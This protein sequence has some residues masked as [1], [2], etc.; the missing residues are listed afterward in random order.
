MSKDIYDILRNRDIP[1][2]VRIQLKEF[3]E[4]YDGF[5]ISGQLDEFQHF[6]SL[7]EN[8]YDLIF[9][10]NPAGQIVYVSPRI[11]RFGY[12]PEEVVGQDMTLFVHPEDL[13][14]VQ[15]DF[16]LTMRTGKTFPTAFRM[17]NKDG[18]YTHVE[19]M[20]EAEWEN[21]QIVRF[22]GTLRDITER[23]LTEDALTEAEH[24]YRSMFEHI[25]DVYFK[26]DK[27]G[28]LTLISPSGVRLLGYPTAMDV[29]GINFPGT[30]FCRAD[31]WKEIVVHLDKHSKITNHEIELRDH[32]G[33]TIQVEANLQA[34]YDNNARFVGV[35]GILRDITDKKATKLARRETEE[36]YRALVEQSHDAIFIYQKDTTVFANRQALALTGFTERELYRKNLW[37]LLHSEDRSV[38]LDMALSKDQNANFERTK[39]EAR[40]ITKQGETRYIE[41]IV[42]DIN[43]GGVASSLAVARD[44]TERKNIETKLRAQEEKYRLLVESSTVGIAIAREHKI[45]F[46]NQALLDIT[47]IEKPEDIRQ[48]SMASLVHPKKRPALKQVMHEFHERGEYPHFEAELLRP[49]RKECFVEVSCT[50]INL[51]GQEQMQCSFIDITERRQMERRITESE[52][53]NRAV[54]EASFDAIFIMDIDNIVF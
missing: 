28:I 8:N 20:S 22:N 50:G 24:K 1:E 15:T 13:E 37:E 33:N 19:E 2:Q 3:L 26:T 30:C 29:L 47:G 31:D 46:T 9:A 36:R 53:R 52:E 43:Y 18:S 49:D 32:A 48:R 16:R 35:E 45:D 34:V 40:I 7:V 4:T 27:S 11:E 54:V 42:G 23:K 25:I 5:N 6:R 21:G 14:T 10:Y 38:I 44:I 41:F 51:D 39:F 12:I 17:K